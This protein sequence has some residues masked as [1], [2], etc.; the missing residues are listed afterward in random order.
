MINPLCITT[1]YKTMQLYPIQYNIGLLVIPILCIMTNRKFT[2]IIDQHNSAE[3]FWFC[4]IIKLIAD[5]LSLIVQNKF[6]WQ[7]ARLMKKTLIERLEQANIKCGIPLPGKL[8]HNIQDLL[9][10]Q[11]QLQDFLIIIPLLWT[12][13]ISF[14]YSI[15]SIEE[16]KQ[17]PLKTMYIISLISLFYIMVKSV[18]ET[19]YQRT[20]P[21][22]SS[23]IKFNNPMYVWLKLSLGCKMIVDFEKDKAKKI[24]IQQRIQRIS[25]VILNAIITIILLLNNEPKQ[26]YSFCS[27]SWMLASL[28][29]NI[30]SLKYYIYMDNL[31]NTIVLLEKHKLETGYTEINPKDI[32]NVYFKNVYFGYYN[33]DKLTEIDIKIRN[34]SI[35]FQKGSIYYLEAENGIGKSTILKIFSNN[36][37]SGNIFYNNINRNEITFESQKKLLIHYVQSSEYTPNFTK[38]EL[39]CYK[40][41]NV[42][43]EKKLGIDN[44]WDKNMSEMSGGMKKRLMIFLALISPASIVLLDETLAELSTNICHEVNHPSGWLGQIIDTLVY[45]KESSN[46]I[47]ILVGH[48]LMKRMPDQVIMLNITQT[49]EKTSLNYNC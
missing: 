16:N 43:L 24:E 3:D 48:G 26:I 39:K 34:L 11:N 44:L 13:L 2:K 45:S 10:D 6:L 33:N 20:K 27:M 12:T 23:I 9:D 35:Q 14:S 29:D 49:A 32:Q 18:D 46:K 22:S 17:Y 30:K 37:Y 41:R 40:D 36:L 4:V 42:T 47:I 38:E 7:S 19:L 28:A 25:M 5:I 8:Y 31:L 15:I 21:V 1:I